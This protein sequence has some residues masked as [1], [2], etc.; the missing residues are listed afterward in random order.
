[1]SELSQCTVREWI[2]PATQKQ[3]ET[4][5]D[6][7]L[8]GWRKGNCDYSLGAELA[9]YDAACESVILSSVEEGLKELVELLKETT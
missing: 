7:L 1:M 5:L 4:I 6:S 2:G 8:P 9:K 3:I